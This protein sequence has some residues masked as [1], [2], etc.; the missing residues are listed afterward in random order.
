LDGSVLAV[1]A[2]AAAPLSGLQVRKLARRGSYEGVRRVL[3]RLVGEGVVLAEDHGNSVAYRLNREHVAA[4]AVLALSRLRATALERMKAAIRSWRI[5]PVHASAF[6]SFARGDG[7]SDSDIDLLVVRPD[8]VSGDD[9]GWVGQL[10]RLASDVEGWTGNHA[11]I[12]ELSEAEVSRAVR[13]K[14]PIVKELLRD[15]VTLAGPGFD[16]LVGRRQGKR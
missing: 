2:R 11:A 9:D 15:A 12:L 4:E 7:G 5:K 3:H 10:A 6:G 16:S 13:R 14:E 1:L 8:T